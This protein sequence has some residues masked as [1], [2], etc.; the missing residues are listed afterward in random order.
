MSD[1]DA[2]SAKEKRTR[3]PI[4]ERSLERMT[5][6]IEAAERMLEEL[7]PEKTSIPALAEVS[8]VPRASIYP[9]F[10][11]KYA[12]FAHIAQI[13]MRHLSEAIANSGA[14]RTRTL[15]TWVRTVLDTCVEY[16]NAHPAAGVLLLNGSFSDADRA[17]HA[18]KNTSIGQQLRDAA[19]GFGELTTLPVS[20]D[21]ATIAVEIGFACLKFGY[22][23][24]GHIDNAVRNEAFRAVMAYL[25]HWRE[26]RE[27]R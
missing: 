21:V 20:P 6:V 19:V 26:A 11:D 7:G 18:G 15:H 22:A 16:Y 17:A 8:G 24:E 27:P 1:F 4:Q 25:D 12:L 9:F 2:S 13:H 23:Q 3:R 10:P 14:A 5:R